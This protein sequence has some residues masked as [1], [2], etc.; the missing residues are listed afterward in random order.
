MS[1]CRTRSSGM[2]RHTLPFSFS[3]LL[4][5]KTRETCDVSL[6]SMNPSLGNRWSTF[7][8][9]PMSKPIPTRYSSV[10]H[11]PGGL[12]GSCHSRRHLHVER[13]KVR[14]SEPEQIRIHGSPP[15]IGFLPLLLEQRACDPTSS[16]EFFQTTLDVVRAMSLWPGKHSC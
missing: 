9:N 12:Y 6:L 14:W 5:H 10:T 4:L 3:R 11:K 13:V 16:I 2:S 7:L 8:S 15:V 1:S